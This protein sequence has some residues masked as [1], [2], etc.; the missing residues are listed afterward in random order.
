VAAGRK[1]SRADPGKGIRPQQEAA[2]MI[3]VKPDGR[4]RCLRPIE[5]GG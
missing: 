3:Q 2:G 1:T 5:P 4:A